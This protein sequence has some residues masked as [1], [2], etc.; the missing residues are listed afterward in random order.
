MKQQMG[1]IESLQTATVLSTSYPDGWVIDWHHH[2]FAQ[3]V[4]ACTGVMTVET[5]DNLWVIPPQ[6]A[7][8]VPPYIDHKVSMHGQADMRNLY[9]RPGCYQSLPEKSG[10]FNVSPL[11]R[12]LVLHLASYTEESESEEIK[13]IF[14]VVMDQLKRA[15][16]TS[17]YL[18][19]ATDDRL[20]L[21]CDHVLSQPD[22]NRTLVQ[23]AA[24]I[25]ISS[26]SLSRLFR[27]DVGL[28]FVEYRQQ[29]R[30]L[31]ALKLLAKGLPVT[32]VAL[33]VGFSSLSAF[34][35]LFKKSLGKTPGHF[36]VD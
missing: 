4:Y 8:W 32:S 26:R 14:Q 16:E 5:V 33:D 19:V 2:D 11:L 1:T 12:E 13:R 3:L 25:N 35:S 6:R 27:T 17:F 9:V 20:K 29:A 21:V 18:P 28:S 34:N 24:H 7:V 23:W 30:L 10:V 31:A 22:D 15:S 36:F